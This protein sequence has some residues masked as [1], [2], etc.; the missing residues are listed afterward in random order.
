MIKFY[1][2]VGGPNPRKVTLALEEFGL[3]YQM[4]LVDIFK[5]EQHSAGYRAINPNGKVPAIEDD[6]VRVFDSNAILLYLAGKHGRFLGNREDRGELLSWLMFVATG[7]SPFSGQWIHFQTAGAAD[8]GDYAKRRYGFEAR[9]HYEVMDAH[10]ADKT[11][12]LGDEYSIV[13]MA[14]WGWVELHEGVLGAGGLDSYPNVKAWY[15]RVNARPAAE[16]ARG[17][18]T[19]GGGKPAFDEEAARALFPSNF[20]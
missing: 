8:G 6:G 7:L 13:D 17:L 2:Y 9:R 14:A 12:F 4:V 3:D 18:S 19:T 5:G 1:L 15:D 16:R 10:L 11:H 20:N